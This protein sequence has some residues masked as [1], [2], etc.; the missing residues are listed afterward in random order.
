MKEP[1]ILVIAVNYNTF[2]ETIRF[3]ESFR[4]AATPSTKLIL[5]DNSDAPIPSELTN[6]IN[7]MPAA[8]H[9][10]TGK[11]L[12]YFNAASAGLAHGLEG[13]TTLPD[14]VLVTNVDITFDASFFKRLSA[15]P[16]RPECG[17]VAPSI[18]SQRWHTDR[19]PQLM[20]PYTRRWLLFL[21]WLYKHPLLHNGYLAAAYTRN[22]ISGLWK[23]AE[24]KIPA[25]TPIY[26]AHGSCLVFSRAYF[27]K[28]G[29]LQIPHFL[30]GEEILVAETA[31]KAGLEIIYQP[32]LKVIDYEHASV[33][34]FVN[35]R[36]NRFYRESIDVI[37]ERF[38]S[39]RT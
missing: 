36:T 21:K 35:A 18:I 14:W 3:L 2:G 24:T 34:L 4:I 19:N 1:E 30:F 11:N 13:A 22:K 15:L 38:Y 37:L 10:V 29:S 12:G 23:R 17:L 32:D 27:E 20:G 31:R 39:D 8:T 26:A 7:A 33:G 28:G 9:F 5:T 6:R 25:G 16:I